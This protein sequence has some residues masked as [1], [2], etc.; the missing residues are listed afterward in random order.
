[1]PQKQTKPNTIK[2]K[3]KITD[4]TK[5]STKK[6]LKQQQQ[7]QR[8]GSVDICSKDINQLLMGNP[9]VSIGGKDISA[10]WKDTARTAKDLDK[11][12]KTGWGN[13]PGLPPNPNCVIL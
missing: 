9:P 5:I 12:G 3:Q 2:K 13:Y 10:V 7:H 1:M 8:G 6:T 4:E 11:Y